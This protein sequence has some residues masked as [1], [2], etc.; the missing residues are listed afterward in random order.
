MKK[1]YG[2]V[3]TLLSILFIFSCILITAGCGKNESV[4][5]AEAAIRAIGDVDLNSTD[6]IQSARE[7]FAKLS[8]EEK[9]K[10]G[11]YK[12]LTE[13]VETYE[14]IKSVS[15]DINTVI[16]ASET[17][18]SDDTFNVSESLAKI[19]DIKTRYGE[20][21]KR[22]RESVKD[23]DKLDAAEKKLGGYVDNAKKAAVQYVKAFLQTEKGKG[24][25]VT[26]VYC[27]KQIRSEGSEYHFFALT[28]KGTDGKERDIYAGARVSPDV[29]VEAIKRNEDV[30]FA[31]APRS[32]DSDAKK[33]GNI[34]LNAAD[35]LAAA[36]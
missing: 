26:A 34:T 12:K 27:I 29:S 28:F 1:S 11:N 24:A 8:P 7:A 19:N 5:A 4:K 23:F 13:A 9:E 10:V 25:D 15:D 16:K 20:L 14:K 6:V 31:S 32:L 33:H 3:A 2:A 18:F 17:T 36:K 22:Q 35:L 30:F 21:K